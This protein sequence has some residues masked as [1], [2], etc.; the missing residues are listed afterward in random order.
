MNFF[1]EEV[2][3]IKII[4][5]KEDRL[6]TNI[7]PDLKAQLLV[8]IG[9]GKS[10]LLNLEDVQYADSSGLGAILLG[11]RQARDA[12]GQFAICNVQKRVETMI[13][14]AQLT[15]IIKIYRDKED[16]LAQMKTN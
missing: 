2:D 8:L 14:I 13:S 3:G 1:L 9:E 10:V 16:A 12:G 4:R 15:N 7:A 11:F 5:I 6:D